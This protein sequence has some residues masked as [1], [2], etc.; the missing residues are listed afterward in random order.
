MNTPKWMSTLRTAIKVIAGILVGFFGFGEEIVSQ[1][2]DLII[3]A[4]S[5]LLAVWAWIQSLRAPE[6][7][8]TDAQYKALKR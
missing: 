4:V 1:G 3:A 2:G 8:I 5:A 7:Q 6:K